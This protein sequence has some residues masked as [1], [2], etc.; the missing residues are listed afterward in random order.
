M[1]EIDDKFPLFEML[2][3]HEFAWFPKIKTLTAS[4]FLPN[5]NFFLIFEKKLKISSKFE[6]FVKTAKLSRYIFFVKINKN[7][8]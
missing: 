8:L 3:I 4:Y 7:A 5:N 1:E 2:K 6:D